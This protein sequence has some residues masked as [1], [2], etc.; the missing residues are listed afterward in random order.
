MFVS[1]ALEEPM[2][3][4]LNAHVVCVRNTFVTVDEITPRRS[5]ALSAPVSFF[6]GASEDKTRLPSQKRRETMVST[7]CDSACDYEGNRALSGCSLSQTDD[8]L[9]RENTL[10]WVMS[11]VSAMLRNIPNRYTPRSLLEELLRDFS[12]RILFFYCP[13]DLETSL[14]LGY[15]F[16]TFRASEDFVRFRTVYHGRKLLRHRSGKVCEVAVAKVQGLEEN[17]EFLS[18]STAL[19]KLPDIYKPVVFQD[20]RNPILFPFGKNSGSLALDELCIKPS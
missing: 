14:G 3:R 5:R 7:T 20:G 13:V 10:A 12:S 8:L 9:I 16:V 18:K 15:C 19:R 4:G 1:L 11:P 17:L 6:L 2:A